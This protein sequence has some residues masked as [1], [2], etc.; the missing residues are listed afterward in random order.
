MIKRFCKRMY[1]KML[2]H[3]FNTCMKQHS[4]LK[5][6][7]DSFRFLAE[8]YVDDFKTIKCYNDKMNLERIKNKDKI[9]FGF[10]VYTSSMWNVDEL[11]HLLCNNHRLD[12]SVIVGLI[13]M[14]DME[15][16]KK[17]YDETLQYF[18]EKNYHVVE[19]KNLHEEEQ[20]DIL[21]YLTPFRFHDEN[22]DLLQIPLSTISLH[23]S[24]SYMLAGNMHKLDLWMYHWTMRYYTDSEYYNDL[25]A[26][27]KYY[28]GNAVYLGFSKMD[29]YYST[30]PLRLSEKK[31]I[32]YAPH[33]SVHYTEFKAATFENNYRDMLNLAKKYA[34]STYWIY[35]PHPLLRSHSVLGK[36]FKSVE[37]YDKYENEWDSLPNAKVITGGDYFSVFK[38]SDAMITDSVSFLAEYQFT[39]N[40]LLLLESGMESYNEFGQEIVCILYKCD[41]SAISEIEEFVVNVIK[42]HDEMKHERKQFFEKNLSY[43]MEGATA[44]RR[45]YDDIVQLLDGKCS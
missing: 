16:A 31:V 7:Y 22:I 11:Y 6:K 32:I 30:D 29:K 21:F 34:D 27:A 23:T 35:K 9:R 12:T 18:V 42:D 38:G 3:K 2:I 15:S 28:T 10:V 25:I 40:P 20:F 8:N 19:A 43:I 45:M 44:N 33:H 37:E 5:G 17:E 41:G 39:G 24:Y 26:K 13:E 4:P 14:P 1:A 36:V